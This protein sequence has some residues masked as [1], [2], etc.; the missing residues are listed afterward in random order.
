[1]V[2]IIP[3]IIPKDFSDLHDHL[4]QVAGIASLVQIDILDGTLVPIK[5]WPHI[6]TP[7]S[8]FQKIMMEEEGFP[9]WEDIEYEFHLM[10][11]DPSVYTQAWVTAGAKRMCVHYEAFESQEKIIA[12]ASE[13]QGHFGRNGSLIGTDLGL[14]LN[15]ETDV[16]VLPNIIEHFDYVQFMSIDT[17]GSHGM[18]FNTEVLGKIAECRKAFGDLPISVDGGVTLENAKSLIDAGADRLVVGGAIWNS[19]NILDTI[20]KFEDLG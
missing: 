18:P 13:F 5:S 20:E 17:I 19:N 4:E 8:D 7:D 1:M 12:F 16:S 9:F 3:A 14:V 2:E 6:H 11:K 15:M 10:V